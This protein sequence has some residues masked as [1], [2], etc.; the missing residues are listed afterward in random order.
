[1]L[2]LILAYLALSAVFTLFI[3]CA[4][5]LAA[6]A[7]EAAENWPDQVADR[8]DPRVSAL[9]AQLNARRESSDFSFHEAPIE[10]GRERDHA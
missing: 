5:V 3:W 10:Q 2:T 9:A 7:D 1:M 4:C 8:D 6:R